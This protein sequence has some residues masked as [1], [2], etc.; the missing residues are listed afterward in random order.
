MHLRN[1]RSSSSLLQINSVSP[2]ERVLVL[3]VFRMIM[4][5]LLLVIW[6]GDDAKVVV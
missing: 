3:S 2:S 5:M 6:G 4:I 1:Q